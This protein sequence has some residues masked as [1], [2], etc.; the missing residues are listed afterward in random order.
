MHAAIAHPA[1]EF[2]REMPS[3]R[4]CSAH[5]GASNTETEQCSAPARR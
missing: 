1:R 3:D 5:H 4:A 2:F